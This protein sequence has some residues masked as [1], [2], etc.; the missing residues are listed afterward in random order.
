MIL[1]HYSA[2]QGRR[3]LSLLEHNP[4]RL[5]DQGRLQLLTELWRALRQFNLTQLHLAQSRGQDYNKLAD[6]QQSDLMSEAY[7]SLYP[8]TETAPE[9]ELTPAQRQ[10]LD[11]W[12]E[13]LAPAVSD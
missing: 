13:S 6:H 8:A 5:L 2:T 12:L 10:K 3:V 1:D 4:G 9:D 7:Q 11:D